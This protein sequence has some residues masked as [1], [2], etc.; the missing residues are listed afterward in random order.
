MKMNRILA[1]LFFFISSKTIASTL[2]SIILL[3]GGGSVAANTSLNLP[4]T[5][6]LPSV[7]YSVV[8]YIN[9]TYPFQYIF[10]N[11]SFTDTTSSVFSYSLNGNVVRQ[12]QLIAGH[13]IAVI[14]GQFTNPATATLIYTNLD[15][16]NPFTVSNC[17][18]IAVTT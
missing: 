9:T 14:E 5:G 6:L 8:C 13:N 2:S 12:D 17:F 7:R 11:S 18:A 4:L 10:L 16:T 1:S 15:Q 3:P